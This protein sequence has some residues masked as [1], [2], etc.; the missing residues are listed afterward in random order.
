ML[1][2][3]WKRLKAFPS[4]ARKRPYLVFAGAFVVVFSIAFSFVG[5]FGILARQRTQML[6]AATVFLGLPLVESRRRRRNAEANEQGS[7]VYRGPQ[8][9]I[10]EPGAVVLGASS[11]Q[12]TV[13]SSD[14]Q[15]GS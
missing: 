8:T 14:Q 3:S 10:V 9:V 2:V 13:A 5:N 4:L 1:L 15:V 7:E 11:R 12:S 6:P